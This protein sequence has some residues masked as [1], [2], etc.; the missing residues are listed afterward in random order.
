VI[1]FFYLVI[2]KI[3]TMKRN[4]LFSI[5]FSLFL[6]TDAQDAMWDI[7]FFSIDFKN[8]NNLGAYE[9]KGPTTF[10]FE[11][12]GVYRFAEVDDLDGDFVHGWIARSSFTA[13]VTENAPNS[14]AFSSYVM[15]LN[16][17]GGYGIN[18]EKLG[19]FATLNHG[20]FYFF[21]S[22]VGGESFSDS[23]IFPK[24]SFFFR[25]NANWRPFYESADS[26][27]KT[28]AWGIHASLDFPQG[29][30]NAF[31]LGFNITPID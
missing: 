31:M 3:Y 5:L 25:L 29:G 20:I 1:A 15:G 28:L 10:A 26:K 22:E 11:P 16:L 21:G 7:S 8:T 17:G 4:L 23:E 30:G 13:V 27:G 9:D 18:S 14:P 12:F 2:T 6:W 19:V 24:D